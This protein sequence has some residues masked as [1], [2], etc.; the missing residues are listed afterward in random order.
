MIAGFGLLA[1][2]FI[3]IWAMLAFADSE[4]HTDQRD[5]RAGVTSVLALV[6]LALLCSA[7]TLISRAAL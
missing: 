3:A 6:A 7:I 1:A 5:Y 2:M 4:S